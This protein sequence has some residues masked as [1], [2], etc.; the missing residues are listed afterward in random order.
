MGCACV[1][2]Y[3]CRFV[4]VLLIKQ[5]TKQFLETNQF[6]DGMGREFRYIFLNCYILGQMHLELL[7]I[8]IIAF[9][10]I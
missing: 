2:I 5:E 9:K 7:K 8:I 1:R 4:Q 10:V 6:M 3:A